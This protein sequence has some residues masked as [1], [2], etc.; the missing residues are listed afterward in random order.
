MRKWGRRSRSQATRER[1]PR[2]GLSRFG[3]EDTTRT[4]APDNGPVAYK[5]LGPGHVRFT[6]APDAAYGVRK[7][8]DLKLEP[9]QAG[10]PL[11]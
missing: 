9:K 8:I 11:N 3:P 2:R 6:Q 4:Y 1:R 10:P 5:P 7:E